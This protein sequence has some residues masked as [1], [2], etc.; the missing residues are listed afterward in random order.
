MFVSHVI[1]ADTRVVRA[2]RSHPAM[3]YLYAHLAAAALALAGC[4]TSKD[5]STP[6]EAPDL[7]GNDV[8]FIDGM[9]PH[10]QRAIEVHVEPL[11][12]R[13]GDI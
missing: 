1:A 3:K 12:A 11:A 2:L 5:A 9:V 6:P 7:P 13:F 8:S 10:H 4:S